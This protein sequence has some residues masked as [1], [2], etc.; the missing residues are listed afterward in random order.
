MILGVPYLT[1]GI[2]S[3]IHHQILGAMNADVQNWWKARVTLVYSIVL[4]QALISNVYFISIGSGWTTGKPQ[5]GLFYPFNSKPLADRQYKEPTL[6][7]FS[8]LD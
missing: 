2:H 4:T 7:P 5:V 8:L 1:W 6:S 3:W